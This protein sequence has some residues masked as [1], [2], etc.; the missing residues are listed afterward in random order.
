MP[1]A[2]ISTP[3]TLG[4]VAQYVKCG[5]FGDLDTAIIEVTGITEGGMVIPAT[6]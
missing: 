6:S 5:F 1:P 3:P 4:E 2:A